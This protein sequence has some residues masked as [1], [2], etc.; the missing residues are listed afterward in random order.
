M[1]KE[2]Y[3]KFCHDCLYSK[4]DTCVKKH[5]SLLNSLKFYMSNSKI[6]TT[7]KKEIIPGMAKKD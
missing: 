7:G 2:L 6:P 3:G 5:E 1:G 4:C